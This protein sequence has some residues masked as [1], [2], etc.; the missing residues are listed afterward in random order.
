MNKVL[1]QPTYLDKETKRLAGILKKHTEGSSTLA[2]KKYD[3]IKRRAN[4]LA[5]FAYREMSQK[6]KEAASKITKGQI[7]DEL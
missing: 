7:K 3:E 4:I 6:A 1:E 5:A 2:S